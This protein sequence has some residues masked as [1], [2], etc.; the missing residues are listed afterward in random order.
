MP[1][2][3][4]FVLWPLIEITLFIQIGA[5]WGAWN[6]LGYCGLTAVAGWILIQTQG[7][8][9]W[10]SMRN[11][12]EQGDLPV[13][14]IFDGICL[15]LGGILLILPGFFSD[16]V[17]LALCLP[18]VRDLAEGVLRR[19]FIPTPNNKTNP[20]IVDV[21]Y[22]HIVEEAQRID[23]KPDNTVEERGKAD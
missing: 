21:E 15:Y 20:D 12:M 22:S 10:I 13:R 2:V 3:I 23:Y 18:P 14:E 16:A 6:V 7:L 4:L 8:R 11:A 19:H 17:G 5:E 1:F 9:T